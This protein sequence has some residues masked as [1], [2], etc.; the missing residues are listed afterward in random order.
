MSVGY[1]QLEA[2][3]LKGASYKVSQDLFTAT[4]RGQYRLK[5]DSGLDMT[6]HTIATDNLC[7]IELEAVGKDQPPQAGHVTQ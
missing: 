7:L 2:P 3:G 1:F 4:T 5:D 6:C